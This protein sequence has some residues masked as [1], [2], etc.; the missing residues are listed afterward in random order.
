MADQRDLARALLALAQDDV[1]A[2]EALLGA[3]R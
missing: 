1:I 2:A 3:R